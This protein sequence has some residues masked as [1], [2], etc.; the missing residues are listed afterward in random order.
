MPFCLGK[1]EQTHEEGG[2]DQANI[3]PP[4]VAPACVVGTGVLGHRTCDN[5]AD[6]P[7]CK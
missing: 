7:V 1:S 6:L 4:E 2:A 5:R 3:E